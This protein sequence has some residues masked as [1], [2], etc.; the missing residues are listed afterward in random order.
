[1]SKILRWDSIVTTNEC[2]LEVLQISMIISRNQFILV[3]MSL[4]GVWV[5]LK[6]TDE[7]NTGMT[8]RIQIQSMIATI[9]VNVH[10]LNLKGRKQN[11]RKN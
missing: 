6:S 7:G 1:M 4:C 2:G 10:D 3:T 9:H 8:T 11:T 5:Y